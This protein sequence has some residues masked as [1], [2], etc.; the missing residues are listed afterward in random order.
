MKPTIVLRKNVLLEIALLFSVIVTGQDLPKIIHPSPEASALFRFQDYPMDYS[1][2]LPQISIPIYEIKCG[3][4]SVPI[5]I[6]YHAS[7]RR[8][9]DQDG[10]VALS[11]SINTGGS[12]SRTIYGSADFGTASASYSFPY[13][14]VTSGLSNGN[15]YRYFEKIV[16]Y[17]NADANILP[18]KDSEYDVFSYSIGSNSGKF[19]FKD[20]NGIKKPVL[21]P[22]KPFIVIPNYTTTGLAGIKIVDDK[23]V[24]YQFTGGETYGAGN[25]NAMSGWNIAKIISADKTDTISFTYTATS[26]ERVTIS[27]SATLIDMWNMSLENFPTENLTYAENTSREVYTL[28]RITEIKF[29]Q[30]KIVFNLGTGNDKINAIQLLNLNHEVLKTVRFNRSLCYSQSELGYATN[31]LDSVVFCDKSNNSIET[32]AFEYYPLVSSNGQLNPRY[33]DWWGFYNNSGIHDFVPRY[34]NQPYV[35][36]NGVAGAIS[37][38]NSSADRNPS[39]EPLKSGMLK[40]IIYPTGGSSEFIYEKNRCTFLGAAGTAIDGPGLRIFQIKTNDGAGTNIIKTYKYGKNESGYGSIELIPDVTT[41]ASETKFVFLPSPAFSPEREG[42][43]RQRNFLSGFISELSDLSSH[44]VIYTEV[45]EYHGAETSNI[46]KTVY[47][48]DYSPWA[49]S[50]MPGFTSLRI[51]KKHIALCNYWNTPSIILKTDYKATE[52]AG[53]IIYQKRK[54]VSSSYTSTTTEKV[55]GLHVQRVYS[56]P[57]TGK[58]LSQ[59]SEQ[60]VMTS[61]LGA[62]TDEIPGAIYTYSEY[63][64]PAGYKNL[65][66][67]TET[68]FNKDNNYISN[69]TG[70]QYNAQ[71]LITKTTATASDG[72]AIVTDIKF[73]GDYS[74]NAVL[75]KMVNLN[76]LNYPVEQIESKNAVHRKSIRTTYV[77]WGTTPAKIAPQLVEV[78][79]GTNPYEARLRYHNYDAFGNIT[80]VSKA[81]DM[82]ISYVYGYGGTLPVAEVSNSPVKNIFYTS[83]EDPEGNSTLN[84][85]KTGR[86]SRT[87]GYTKTLNNLDNGTYLLTYWQKTGSNWLLQSITVTVSGGTYTIKLT[88]QLDEVRFCPQSALM[89][90]YTYDLLVGMLSHTDAASHTSY[91]EYDDYGRLKLVRDQD[92]NILKTFK[93]QYR[94]TSAN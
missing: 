64:I 76:M 8:V 77:N 65:V 92:G 31:K 52:T 25:N 11:W 72:T 36:S 14:F 15:D 94:G 60:F 32:Y 44:P 2:G 3:S 18:W 56:L 10:P 24:E 83:F 21:L 85:S 68:V 46:G 45:T 71:Q 34:I 63:E 66:A 70:Y 67:T 53:G 16:H 37:I 87:G 81:N 1:T 38:G 47:Q 39:L 86:R 91:Y 50:A 82:I 84:D 48:Y 28:S 9:Y 6:S 57:Q 69:S 80:A 5:S 35:G 59:Y 4:L 40:K 93:Y 89:V 55:K 23:G 33:C 30:G 49:P 51:P 73:P 88:G 74:G 7:G 79:N 19:I 78:K 27:Q 13:P 90:T 22:Y 29:N 62:H 42:T 26:Q 17:D 75:T 12:I 43:Y 20:S 54:E 41:M 58:A 61:Q